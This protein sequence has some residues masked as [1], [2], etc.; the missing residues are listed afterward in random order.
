MTTTLSNDMTDRKLLGASILPYAIDTQHNNLYLL[1]GA[2]RNIPRWHESG[3]FSDFGGRAMPGESAEKCA[4]REFHEE[5]CAT[6]TLNGTVNT[7]E[8]METLLLNQKY[9]FKITTVIDASRYY[10]TFVKQVPFQAD[11]CRVYADV[12]QKLQCARTESRMAGS[13][14]PHSEDEAAMLRSHPAVV[15]DDVSE[16]VLKV[17]KEYIEKQAL[18][19]ISLPHIREAIVRGDM[20]TPPQRMPLQCVILRDTFRWRMKHVLP[21]F[22][23][24]CVRWGG[25][26]L[27]SKAP[28]NPASA[29]VRIKK[30][31]QQQQQQQQQH[32]KCYTRFGPTFKRRNR[33]DKCP[34]KGRRHGVYAESHHVQHGPAKKTHRQRQQGVRFQDGQTTVLPHQHGAQ[35]AKVQIR[36]GCNSYLGMLQ[37]KRKGTQPFKRYAIGIGHFHPT[38][39]QLVPGHNA[40]GHGRDS[41]AGP[42]RDD[43][44]SGGV[45][46]CVSN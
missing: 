29:N 6:V 34:F 9:T 3:K 22:E 42:N 14:T 8:D 7:S 15:M 26:T 2:E 5:T 40:A 10:V 28:V 21:H 27:L 44:Q 1:L 30:Q 36:Y 19:W 43:P 32:R 41:G 20:S 25:A 37:N 45:H 24:A 39:A 11:I 46:I 4:A 23:K 12:L 35:E 16:N 18:Q 13:Y 33:P 31:Q 38:D 17:H